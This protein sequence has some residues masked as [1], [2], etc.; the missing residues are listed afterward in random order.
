MFWYWSS[1]LY[2]SQTVIDVV[3]N[4][5]I[6][7]RFNAGRGWHGWRAVLSATWLVCV[8]PVVELQR[9]VKRWILACYWYC[10]NNH[11]T[12]TSMENMTRAFTSQSVSYL[13]L[14]CVMSFTYVLVT[15]YRSTCIDCILWA[16]VFHTL[17]FINMLHAL[18]N[19]VCCEWT[20]LLILF[21]ERF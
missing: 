6:S 15:V 8:D 1:V 16:L 21:Y 3:V 11:F 4:Y 7:P 2:G 18:H 19:C 5:F 17:I 9:G 14:L 10:R 13:C 20:Q 12:P